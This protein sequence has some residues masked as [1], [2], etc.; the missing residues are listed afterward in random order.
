[1]LIRKGSRI[2]RTEASRESR[3][4]EGTV[5]QKP[6]T[7]TS[8]VVRHPDFLFDIHSFDF[9]IELNNGDSTLELSERG[10]SG[11]ALVGN[12]SEIILGVNYH[13]DGMPR[14]L[15]KATNSRILGRKS[16]ILDTD[17]VIISMENLRV[18]ENE[19]KIH[20]SGG[21]E[22]VE[23]LL[24]VSRDFV[25]ETKKG[26][27]K[28]HLDHISLLVRDADEIKDLKDLFGLGNN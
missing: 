17:S 4:Y 8:L 28:L 12:D 14:N 2:V 25:I 1:M 19:L 11:R 3:R 15:S 7:V 13:K 27:E 21:R 10:S 26:S 24:G 20:K 9:E 6:L 22:I 16:N 5:S 23:L 18:S